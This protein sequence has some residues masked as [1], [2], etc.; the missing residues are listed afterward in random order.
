MLP[1]HN[2]HL[3]SAIPFVGDP[4][5]RLKKHLIADWEFVDEY[6]KI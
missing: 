3:R 6:K 2:C 1:F 4:V 5:N